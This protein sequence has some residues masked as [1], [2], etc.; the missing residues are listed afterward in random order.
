MLNS[1]H[2]MKHKVGIALLGIILGSLP[3]LGQEKVYPVRQG[4]DTRVFVTADR[5]AFVVDA[6]QQRLTVGFPDDN[7]VSFVPKTRT[8]LI[9]LW[10][11]IQNTSTRPLDLDVAKFNS[12]DDAGRKS[13][14]LS[15]EEAS[16]KIIEGASGGSL[17]AKTLRGIS[18]GRVGNAPT[19]DQL[20]DD[21]QRYS[22][23][24]GQIPAGVVRQGLVYFEAPQKKKF[25]VSIVLGDLWS[26]PLVFSTEK[27]K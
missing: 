20:K 11:R 1:L 12:T 5:S 27:Q 26:S 23:Q 18:L 2:S 10:I 25:T 7:E 6:F 15:I 8:P 4:I 16:K 14:A 9:L 3:L 24:S 19:E 13:S 22:L 21:I 17:G